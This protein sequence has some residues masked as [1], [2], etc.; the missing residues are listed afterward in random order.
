MIGIQA[1]NPKGVELEHVH[2]I[3]VKV[4]NGSV[5]FNVEGML[6]NLSNTVQEELTVLVWSKYSPWTAMDAGLENRWLN[7]VLQLLTRYLA[8][9]T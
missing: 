4:G 3:V 5:Q 9:L 2:S 6:K 1:V 7:Q 8:Q